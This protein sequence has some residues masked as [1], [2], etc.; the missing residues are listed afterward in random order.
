MSKQA[1]GWVH[2]QDPHACY[3]LTQDSG[4]FV[5]SPE[6]HYFRGHSGFGSGG[7]A[8]VYQITATLKGDQK[9]YSPLRSAVGTYL[10]GE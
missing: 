6:P 2:F 4:S 3:P 9:F 8:F 10:V 5:G 1:A 7:L